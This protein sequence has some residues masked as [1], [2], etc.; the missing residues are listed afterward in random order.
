MSFSSPCG[1]EKPGVVWACARKSWA[2]WTYHSAAST[3]L[4]SG[5]SPASGNRLGRSPSTW[6][7]DHS[8]RIWRAVSSRPVARHSP[9]IAR[10]VSRPQSVNQGYPAMMVEAMPRSTMYASAARVRPAPSALRRAASRSRSARTTSAVEPP[11]SGRSGGV[12]VV[13]IRQ[14]S[15]SGP[16]S[17]NPNSPGEAQSSTAS[18]PRACSWL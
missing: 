4:N 9:R 13:K 11:G 10:K 1:S 16:G 3:E 6:A 18:S 8:T 7:L 14:A 17:A 5:A 15:S 2:A 12:S